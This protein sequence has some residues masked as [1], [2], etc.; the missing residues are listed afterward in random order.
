MINIPID[1]WKWGDPENKKSLGRIIIYNDGTGT[2]ERGNYIVVAM[3]KRKVLTGA[4]QDFP[5]KNQ[6]SL[7]LLYEALRDIYE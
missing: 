1:L 4:V 5:R 6:D 2:L 7:R 3:G